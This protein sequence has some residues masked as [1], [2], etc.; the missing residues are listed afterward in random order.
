MGFLYFSKAAQV[1]GTVYALLRSFHANLLGLNVIYLFPTR[2][3]VMD[4]SK[5]RVGPLLAE[6]PFL[7]KLMTDTDTAGLKKIGNAY[8]YLRGMQS[9]V[10][11]KSVP[12]DLLIFDEL[13]EAEPA[14]KAM[15]RERLSHSSYKRIIELSNPSLPD[16]GIDES[17]QKSD[18][19][20][21]TLKCPAC[22][23]W[24]ALDKVF[25]QKQGQEVRILL[26][27]PDGTVYR[28]CPRCAHE[29]DT[30]W[31]RRPSAWPA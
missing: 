23:E 24:T 12:A 19:R 15:A 7:A 29:L 20:H 17:F 6:N 9:S 2:S 13:D 10:G 3:D 28:A 5:S 16:Y 21:W 30:E 1:G 4:F 18:Q 8:L 11:L 22:N 25:P 14:A 27:R 26:P 31:R